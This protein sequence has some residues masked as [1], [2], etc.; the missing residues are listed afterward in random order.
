VRI[1]GEGAGCGLTLRWGAD[2][3]WG[4]LRMQSPATADTI[5]TLGRNA[6]NRLLTSDSSL[7]ESALGEYPIFTVKYKI[8]LGGEP[9]QHPFSAG[10]IL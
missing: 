2:R 5:T 7:R 4:E 1:R 3:A 9:A 6:L 8:W 10:Y